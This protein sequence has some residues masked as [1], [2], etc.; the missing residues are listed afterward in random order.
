MDTP[1]LVAQKTI[2]SAAP[3]NSLLAQGVLTKGGAEAALKLRNK[4]LSNEQVPNWATQMREDMNT[5]FDEINSALLNSRAS[6]PFSRIAA[7]PN[8]AGEIPPDFPKT[9]LDFEN[10]TFAACQE[11]ALFY[12]IPAVAG[13]HETLRLYLGIPHNMLIYPGTTSRR[14]NRDGN[15][16]DDNDNNNNN[17]N[18]DNDDNDDDNNNNNNNNSTR[19]NKTTTRT[20]RNSS[21]S[22]SSTAGRKRAETETPNSSSRK[23]L[24][25]SPSLRT[26]PENSGKD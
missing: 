13:S 19:T 2:A 11:L 17:N 10:L 21:G 24:R 14:N 16:G 7:I 1:A 26:E 22:G 25:A 5:R 8:N 12:E 9:R 20:T 15:V 23:K 3:Y 6:L 4:K 18:N